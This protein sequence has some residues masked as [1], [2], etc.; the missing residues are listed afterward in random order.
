MIKMRMK[1]NIKIN[2][3]IKWVYGN[4]YKQNIK[5]RK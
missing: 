5:K 1:I 3:Y 2:V 4:K